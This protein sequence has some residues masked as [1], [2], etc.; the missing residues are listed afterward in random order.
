[1]G[2]MTSL[3]AEFTYDLPLLFPSTYCI[4]GELS[5]KLCVSRVREPRIV[6]V[7]WRPRNDNAIINKRNEWGFAYDINIEVV[8]FGIHGK[9][10]TFVVYG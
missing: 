7:L 4:R 6:I 9:Y 10:T 2:Y 3:A 5:S 1:M 8:T